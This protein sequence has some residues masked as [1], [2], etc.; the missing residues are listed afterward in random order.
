MRKI[1]LYP[2]AISAG[3][4]YEPGGYVEVD[5]LKP[6]RGYWVKFS[7]LQSRDINGTQLGTDTIPVV[8]GWNMIGALTYPILA[9]SVT[10]IL[11]VTFISSFFGYMNGY[12]YYEEDTLKPGQ[13]YWLKVSHAGNIV[14]NN[15]P[16]LGSS[17][18]TSSPIV[19]VKQNK[20]SNEQINESEKVSSITVKDNNGKERKLYFAVTQKKQDM[21]RYELP[22]LPPV[23]IL[24]VRYSS[25]RYVEFTDAANPSRQE[26]PIRINGGE[27]PMVFSWDEPENLNMTAILEIK[28]FGEKPK[29]LP[30]VGKGN[31]IL[32]EENASSAKLVILPKN[33]EDL[34]T[35]LT[36]HQ[37][38]PNPFNPVTKIRYDLPKDSRVNLKVY[39]ILGQEIAVLVDEVQQA[40]Y[41]IIEWDTRN[42]LNG[43]LCSGI[44][45]YR[46]EVEEYVSIKK[47]IL[48]K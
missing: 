24:D 41:K 1:A 31:I 48:L 12:G 23:E 14:I 46:L 17:S 10:P 21:K 43:D 42:T 37:N 47:L 20:K 4:I 3:F 45:F 44:Y 5:T 13:G 18:L 8:V 39:N 16:L 11:P 32:R 36:L 33:S 38:Y 15:S 28:Q 27:F 6:S 25:Q 40:G 22:P 19:L 7:S 29:E 34:P 26:F 35:E 30:L 2:T 9:S